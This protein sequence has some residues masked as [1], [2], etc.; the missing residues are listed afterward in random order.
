MRAV[1]KVVRDI[2]QTRKLV[3]LMKML[4][5]FRICAH[6]Y[7][8]SNNLDCICMQNTRLDMYDK[9]SEKNICL[10]L[11]AQKLHNTRKF[12]LISTVLLTWRRYIWPLPNGCYD[13]CLCAVYCWF[14]ARYGNEYLREL[15][16]AC[17]DRQ[18]VQ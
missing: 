7:Q 4:N 18:G 17:K 6:A 8:L 13:R 9:N 2:L 14:L 10:H 16:I 12:H 11:Q 5:N 3:Q 1:H 15:G